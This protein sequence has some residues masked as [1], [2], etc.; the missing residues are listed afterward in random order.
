MSWTYVEDYEELTGRK[1]VTEDDA[2]ADAAPEAPV[3][4]DAGTVETKVLTA[5]KAP[6][7]A[8]SGV[9]VETA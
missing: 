5:P 3:V 9:Q 4:V 2:P 1:R 6:A 8:P 7:V